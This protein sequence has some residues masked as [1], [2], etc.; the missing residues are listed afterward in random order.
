MSLLSNKN[1]YEFDGERLVLNLKSAGKR[2]SIMPSYM[3]TPTRDADLSIETPPT[4]RLNFMDDSD[5][6]GPTPSKLQRTFST[7]ENRPMLDISTSPIP[8]PLMFDTSDSFVVEDDDDCVTPLPSQTL[9]DSPSFIHCTET[10][11]MSDDSHVTPPKV[12]R[13]LKRHDSLSDTKLLA[14]GLNRTRSTF[15]FESHFDF[16]GLLGKGSFSEVFR[17]R[18]SKNG[19][20]FLQ[21]LCSFSPFRATPDSH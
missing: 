7:S 2:T 1:L 11:D 10:D 16:L 4:R 9:L 18:H 15:L 14:P 5:E 19:K 17:V 3:H 8:V 6:S 12:D 20:F 21:L 13:V